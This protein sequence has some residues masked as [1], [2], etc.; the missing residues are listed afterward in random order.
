M[1]RLVEQ[2]IGGSC[3]ERIEHHRLVLG[4]GENGDRGGG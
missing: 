3:L 1:V 2:T 4:G